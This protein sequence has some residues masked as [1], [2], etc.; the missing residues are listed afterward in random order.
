MEKWPIDL[1]Y[2]KK[3]LNFNTPII[4][5][6]DN[7]PTPPQ[8]TW[9]QFFIAVAILCAARSKDPN[10]KH[11]SVLVDSHNRILS[12]GYNSYIAGA[13]DE[14]LSNISPKKYDYFKHAEANC[15][16]NAPVDFLSQTGL[17]LY[18]TGRPCFHCLNRIISVGI[19]HIICINNHPRWG[20]QSLIDQPDGKDFINFIE[21]FNMNLEWVYVKNDDFYWIENEFNKYRGTNDN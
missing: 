13:P 1:E 6:Q 19:K 16:D 21:H 2:Y 10:T 7:L 11:G 15:L 12:T 17:R 9:D 8:P 5:N 4:N 14:N 3:E 20:G 18:I